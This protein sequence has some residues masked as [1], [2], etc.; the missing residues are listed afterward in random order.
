MA[1]QSF[2]NQT[3]KVEGNSPLW[4][5]AAGAFAGLCVVLLANQSAT[6]LHSSVAV[7]T[8][9]IVAQVT[10]HLF[11]FNAQMLPTRTRWPAIKPHWHTMHKSLNWKVKFLQTSPWRFPLRQ[12]LPFWCETLWKTIFFFMD[13]QVGVSGGL[14]LIAGMFFNILKKPSKQALPLPAP[15]QSVSVQFHTLSK[16]LRLFVRCQQHHRWCVWLQGWQMPTHQ[17]RWWQW[18]QVPVLPQCKMCFWFLFSL[19]PFNS[20]TI[21]QL[22]S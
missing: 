6:S 13:I 14:L 15:L 2:T 11:P 20:S 1:Y 8:T 10:F 16:M 9:P 17:L 12:T 4:A 21:P 18:Q 19:I 7:P 3:K 5:V 22:I